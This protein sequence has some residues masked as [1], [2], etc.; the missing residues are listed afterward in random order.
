MIHAYLYT[1]LSAAPKR[2]K[3]MLASRPVLQPQQ[4]AQPAVP[5]SA[6]SRCGGPSSD[7]SPDGDSPREPD[8]N[9][10]AGQAR[11]QELERATGLTFIQRVRLGSWRHC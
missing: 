6:G 2:A 5:S 3:E 4:Y 10:E 11:L 8:D 1:D 7:D 9:W